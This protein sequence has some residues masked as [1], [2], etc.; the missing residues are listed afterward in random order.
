MILYPFRAR[1][2]LLWIC[3]LAMFMPA[4]AQ[5]KITPRLDVSYYEIDDA[6]RFLRI[7]VR[8]RVDKRFEPIADAEVKCFLELP[9]G[10]VEAG[11]VTTNV[12]GEGEILLPERLVTAMNALDEYT[13]TAEIVERDSLEAVSEMI[14]VKS[15]RL[16]IE[17]DDANKSIRV[18]LHAKTDGAW[19]P[20]ADAELGVFIKRQFGRIPVGE[21]IYTTD[22]NGVVELTFDTEI[23]GDLDGV[24]TLECVVED[25]DELGNLAASAKVNWGVPLQLSDKF[26]KRS[27]WGTRD[28]TPWWLLVFPNAIIAGVWGVI[29]YLFATLFRIKRLARECNDAS[30]QKP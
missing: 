3:A 11:S 15:S 1:R 7:H 2:F 24:I 9:D 5:N 26:N 14:A 16:K 29:V 17:T 25:N 28:K 10:T 23:P 30:G 6:T 19:E 8:Q 18:S 21:D 20:F 4:I 13:F 22:E 12:N 27:L